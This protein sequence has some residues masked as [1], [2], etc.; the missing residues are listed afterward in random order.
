MTFLWPELLWLL[1]VLPLLLAAYVLVLRRK[2]KLALR[3]ASLAHGAARRW[4]RASASR[5]HVPPVLFLLALAAML[6]AIARPQAAITLPSQ[7]ETVIL[8]MDVSG[9][10]RATDVEPNRLVAAQNAAKAVRRRAAA[11]TCASAWSPSPAP[12]RWCRRRRATART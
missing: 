3:Y 12:P 9:S 4:A 2:K 8:A 10:M 6:L 5:R 7:H 1:L 11:R